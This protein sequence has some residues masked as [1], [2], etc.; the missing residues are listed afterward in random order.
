[1]LASRIYEL[2]RILFDK[3][4]YNGSAARRNKYG[5]VIKTGKAKIAFINEKS[6]YR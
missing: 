2:Q 6:R 1:M 5:K 3:N 4:A